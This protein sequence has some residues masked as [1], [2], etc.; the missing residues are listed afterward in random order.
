[1]LTANGV[2]DQSALGFGAAKPR[3][4]GSTLWW[5]A[6]VALSIPA[7]PAADLRWPIFDFTE[8]S[9]TEPGAKP[10]PANASARLDSST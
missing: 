4:G 10:A 3:L 9:A 6:S 5:I 2:D 7:A 1:M 8:P